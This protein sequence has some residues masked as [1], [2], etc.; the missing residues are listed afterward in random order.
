MV[1]ADQLHGEIEDRLRLGQELIERPVPDEAALKECKSDYYTWSEYNVALLRRSFDAEGPADEYTS[2]LIA[3]G[4]PDAFHERVKELH[5]DIESKMRRLRSLMERLSLFSV[6]PDAVAPTVAP[7][8]SV[9]GDDVFIVHGHDDQTKQIVARFVAQLVGREPVILHEQADRGRTIIEKFED[10]AASAA[11]AIV[12][13]TGDDIGGMKDGST[14]P[15]AR[16][17]VV[18]ELGF[19]LGKLGRG[20]VVILHETKVELPSDLNGI[21]YVPLDESGA[22]R[23]SVAR[24]VEA[25][26][27]DVNL[28]ALLR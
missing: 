13:L 8:S 19:F 17:N 26:G 25:A 28:K 18:L 9:I 21:L 2:W 12:L 11:C 16:Q 27:V 1:P 10:H 20:R 15:R 3:V 23:N 24:E 4:P 7:D 14:G 6:H 5:E 22:W